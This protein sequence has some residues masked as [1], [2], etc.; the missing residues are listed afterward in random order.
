MSAH[1]DIVVLLL[2]SIIND[3]DC[4]VRTISV[5]REMADKSNLSTANTS[6]DVTDI[7]WHSIWVTQNGFFATLS[8]GHSFSAS[9]IRQSSNSC[10][11]D[12]NELR[13]D[14]RSSARV[15]QV[16]TSRQQWT[17]VF[18]NWSY[19][20]LR[21]P[22]RERWPVVNSPHRIRWRNRWSSIRRM[23]PVHR[24][25]C[26]ISMAW[27]LKQ[28]DLLS[29]SMLGTLSCQWTFRILRK[30]LAWNASSCLMCRW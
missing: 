13:Q 11:P 3:D 2:L 12:F 14:E 24:S 15:S 5:N 1:H 22:P 29:I 20:R 17:S 18:F 21:W 26:C 27:M 23:W 10:T 4:S 28:F 8:F 19:K 30:H 9:L 16:S 7:G 6:T 25:C